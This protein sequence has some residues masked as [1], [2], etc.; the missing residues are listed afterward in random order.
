ME[1][2]TLKD[3]VKYLKDE[4]KDIKKRNEDMDESSWN[5]EQGVLLSGNEAQGILDILKNVLAVKKDK[6]ICNQTVMLAF[7]RQ[8]TKIEEKGQFENFRRI[9]RNFV[10]D[11]IM[12]DH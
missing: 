5:Y 4:I 3:Y 7:I 11:Y 9:L 2:K 1:E 12:E 8:W 10:F 6:N